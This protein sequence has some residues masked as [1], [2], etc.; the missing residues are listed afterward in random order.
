MTP[1]DT[2]K[3]FISEEGNAGI[4][5]DSETYFELYPYIVSWESHSS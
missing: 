4:L 1:I 2:E 5:R 3:H